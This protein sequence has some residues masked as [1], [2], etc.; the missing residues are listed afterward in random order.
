LSLINP[1]FHLCWRGKSIGRRLSFRTGGM[2]M[3]D[4]DIDR[5]EVRPMTYKEIARSLARTKQMLLAAM[6]VSGGILAAGV[7]VLTVWF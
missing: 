2:G 3:T 7:F 4:L 1:V 6:A 5:F